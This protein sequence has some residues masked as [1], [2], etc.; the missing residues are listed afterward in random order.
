ME[1]STLLMNLLSLCNCVPP[2]TF[3]Q[4]RVWREIEQTSSYLE[5]RD[6]SRALLRKVLLGDSGIAARQLASSGL[7]ELIARDAGALNRVFELEATKL[8][9]TALQQALDR[10]GLRATDV[11]A[12]LVCTCTGY[13][14][15]GLSSFVAEK[16]GF[17]QDAHLLDL[18]GLGCGAAL[19]LL[20][21]GQACLQHGA[22]N[23]ACVAVEICS[24]AFY[25]DDDPGVLISFCLFG[26]GASAS[27]WNLAGGRESL[28]ALETVHSLHWPAERESLRF[29]NVRGKLKNV[30]ASSVP[31][32][33]ARAV[34]ELARANA[35]ETGKLLVH[36][37]GK[38]VLEAIAGHF[39]HQDLQESRDVLREHGNMSS[40]SIL[41]V[42]EKWLA[43]GS[44]DE[45]ATLASFGAGF[46]CHLAG[47]RRHSTPPNP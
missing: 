2:G 22:R 10:A 39:P 24:A 33:G 38:K 14:C 28:G 11:D 31:G 13:L 41:F 25:L 17:R 7:Q 47:F 4:D 35:A 16:I 30:L 32:V 21:Q 23:V 9:S 15:P 12:L 44:P 1:G 18:V 27:I 46:S 6:S 3:S 19:P 40:P 36:P 8:A 29:V 5:L 20:R 43:G 42:L 37:G 45:S 26:D 34:A